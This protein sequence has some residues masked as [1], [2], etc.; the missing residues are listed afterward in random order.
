MTGAVSRILSA[1]GR[2]KGA[3]AADNDIG[4]ISYAA[5]TALISPPS[6]PHPKELPASGFGLRTALAAV[7][8]EVQ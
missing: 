3:T 6:L 8:E 1:R 5:H 4:T 7:E 2:Y